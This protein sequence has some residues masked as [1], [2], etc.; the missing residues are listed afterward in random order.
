MSSRPQRFRG[1]APIGRATA[2]ALLVFAGL[3]GTPHAEASSGVQCGD[4]L[5][6]NTVLTK[7]LY[8][9]KDGLKIGAHGITLDLNGY[10]IFGPGRPGTKG[11]QNSGYD[12]VVIS[13][14]ISGQISGGRI[15]GF[16]HGIELRNGADDNEIIQF[17]PRGIRAGTYGLVLF[18][19]D[20]ARVDDNFITAG[21]ANHG[22]DGGFGAAFALYRSHN[23]WFEENWSWGNGV[24][25]F[26][27][28]NSHGNDL[29]E[30]NFIQEIWDDPVAHL[31]DFDPNLGTGLLL[32]NSDRNRIVGN[33][34]AENA[35]DG[36]FL[37]SNSTGNLVEA[38]LAINNNRLGINNRGTNIDGGGNRALGNTW[39]AQCRGIVCAG[40]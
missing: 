4:R 30:F 12:N 17:Y 6:R 28:D 21:H 7:D 23:N 3:A 38:N 26:V 39:S 20:R 37:D 11:V 9:Q 15:R 25:T 24:N 29:T 27:V 8:C 18:D 33:T 19:S 40:Q 5:T 10:T 2:A 34:F 1:R 32:R 22:Y 14:A 36:I 16:D 13:G 35:K 31:N